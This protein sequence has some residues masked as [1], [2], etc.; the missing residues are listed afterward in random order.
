MAAL[1]APSL[2]P[3]LTP[4]W[5][6]FC[7]LESRRGREEDS[8]PTG[9]F[10]SA[11]QRWLVI[12]RSQK[13]AE[14]LLERPDVV[15]PSRA[16]PRIQ[17]NTAEVDLEERA[18]KWLGWV[19]CRA[20]GFLLLI[21][22]G[23]GSLVWLVKLICFFPAEGNIWRGGITQW[24]CTS[25]SMT[26]NCSVCQGDGISGGKPAGG[27]YWLRCW[28][29]SGA[30]GVAVMG[31][32]GQACSAC[33]HLHPGHCSSWNVSLTDWCIHRFSCALPLQMGSWNRICL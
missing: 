17:E 11:I 7:F 23:K 5:L 31:V 33:S 2:A 32:T 4:V 18:K 10:P 26:G 22:S 13:R 1:M 8:A 14:R 6:L 30:T 28:W 21:P 24:Y 20:L 27:W 29:V 9:H 19:E 3:R 16:H 12:Y 15:G 25:A